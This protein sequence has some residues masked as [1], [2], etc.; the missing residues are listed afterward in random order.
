MEDAEAA[1]N[2]KS[3]SGSGEAKQVPRRKHTPHPVSTPLVVT[4]PS[5]GGIK[6]SDSAQV[7]LFFLS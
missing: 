5:G 3:S 1:R 6:V 4:H 2:S 7:N